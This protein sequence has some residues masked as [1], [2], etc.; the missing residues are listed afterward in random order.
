MERATATPETRVPGADLGLA[1]RG[2]GPPAGLGR[3]L[4]D[5]LESNADVRSCKP[6]AALKP[7]PL[8]PKLIALSSS[9]VGEDGLSGVGAGK[10]CSALLAKPQ[11]SFTGDSRPGEAVFESLFVAFLSGVDERAVVGRLLAL[12]GRIF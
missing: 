9:G 3:P 10:L 1:S 12:E 5:W 8:T 4:F 11:A 7:P 2:T 6:L